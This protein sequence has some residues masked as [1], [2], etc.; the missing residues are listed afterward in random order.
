MK[1]R[2]TTTIERRST[3][4]RAGSGNAIG[5]TEGCTT[6]ESSPHQVRIQRDT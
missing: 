6:A 3:G 2:P 4:S 5:A 1:K